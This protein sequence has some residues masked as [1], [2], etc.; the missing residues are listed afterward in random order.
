MTAVAA[1]AFTACRGPEPPEAL[2]DFRTQY[3]TVY[4]LSTERG[5]LLLAEV[6]P[7]E[8]EELAFRYHIG[9]GFF[10]DIATVQQRGEVLSVLQPQSSRPNEVRF[11][12]DPAHAEDELYFEVRDEDGDPDLLEALLLD[13]GKYGDLVVIDEEDS[14]E[15]RARQLTGAGLYAWRDGHMQLVGIG[16]GLYSVSPPALAFIGVHEMAY[17]FPAETTTYFDREARPRRADFEY[18]IPRDLAGERVFTSGMTKV[19]DYPE[20]DLEQASPADTA[21]LE[22]LLESLQAQEAEEAEQ[23]DP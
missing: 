6:L 12:G 1:L 16:N 2:V 19:P 17:T 4:G 22:A 21:A 9:N 13:A 23:D 14:L 18:G 11:A 8:Q 5:I 7:E 3:G 10:D 20:G 15:D